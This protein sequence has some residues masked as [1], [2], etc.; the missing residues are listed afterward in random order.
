MPQES[1]PLKETIAQVEN[2][3][4]TLMD[5]L[6][7]QDSSEPLDPAKLEEVKRLASQAHQ[8]LQQAAAKLEA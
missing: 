2:E 8:V 4:R 3:L 6:V 7:S 1:L 5:L